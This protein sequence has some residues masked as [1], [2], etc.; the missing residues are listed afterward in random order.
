MGAVDLGMGAVFVCDDASAIEF[1]DGLF[2]L[3]DKCGNVEIRR[4]MRPHTFCNCARRAMRLVEEFEQRQTVVEFPF[5]H[6]G[7]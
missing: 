6:D 2:Y 1:K 5:H 7:P 4:A 3:T